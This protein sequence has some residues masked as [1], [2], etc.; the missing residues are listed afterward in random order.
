MPAEITNAVAAIPVDVHVTATTNGIDVAAAP[1][2]TPQ[3]V[4]VTARRMPAVTAAGVK[5]AAYVLSILTL[6]LVFFAIYVWSADRQFAAAV[7]L[8]S[9]EI[10]AQTAIEGEFP[11]QDSIEKLAAIFRDAAKDPQLKFSDADQRDD[12]KLD[13][14]LARLGAVSE[15]QKSKLDGC[16]PPP[17]DA[18]RAT[19]LDACAA[20]LDAAKSA[21]VVSVPLDR[22][23]LLIDYVKQLSDER[24]SFHTSWIQEAQLILLN[25]LLPLLTGLFGYIFGT[26]QVVRSGT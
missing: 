17:T 8:I 18:S 21:K 23:T 26:Q 3:A 24:Q 5:L 13:A 9:K 1:T 22:V 10:V 16:V 11:S 12:Q 6:A 14:S 2:T 25:L 20:I 4:D 7:N 15:P 19:S